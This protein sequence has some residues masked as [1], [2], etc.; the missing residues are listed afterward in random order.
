MLRQCH[1][2][3][4][5]RFFKILSCP[6][7]DFQRKQ[8]AKQCSI[9]DF[10]QVKNFQDFRRSFRRSDVV[11]KSGNTHFEI[12]SQQDAPKILLHLLGEC[13]SISPTISNLFEVESLVDSSCN[14]YGVVSSS[15]DLETIIRL[16][17]CRSVSCSIE[18]FL[19]C[20]L[21]TSPSPRDKRQSRMPSS[22]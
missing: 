16:P 5:K 18:K 21:Y 14:T 17:V 15:K 4:F 12:S 8:Q 1:F 13:A 2:T 7:I 3:I 20:L 6:L 11:I 9:E 22:A 19:D 10:L